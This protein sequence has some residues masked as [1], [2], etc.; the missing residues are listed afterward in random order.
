MEG[1]IPVEV[2]MEVSDLFGIRIAM[3]SNDMAK[4][5]KKKNKVS[6]VILSYRTSVP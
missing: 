5:S 6:M 2:R 3:S 4:K 1:N